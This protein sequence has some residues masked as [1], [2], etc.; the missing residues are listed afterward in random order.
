MEQSFGIIPLR[1]WDKGWKALL[2]Q[3]KAG[4]WAFPKGRREKGESPQETA[5]R[6]LNEE[7]G[8]HVCSF[9]PGVSFHE[10]YE[11]EKGGKRVR[12]KVEYFPAL[13]E[14]KVKLQVKEVV[15]AK[16]V[17]LRGAVN[18]CTFAEAKTLCEK[19]V[20]WF[21]RSEGK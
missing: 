8:L 16:W 10:N 3:H 4:H 15:A 6:E 2:I 13:V 19:L 11:Y 20:I 17:S 18:M 1:K 7:V 14:G 21:S 12:K 5:T 9:F